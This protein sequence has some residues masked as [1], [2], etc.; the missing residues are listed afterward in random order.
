MGVEAVS[1]L[2]S[3]A[4]IAGGSKG[5][6]QTLFSLLLISAAVLA[7]AFIYNMTCTVTFHTTE[8]H[9]IQIRLS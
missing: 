7:S 4:G 6:T 9:P 5:P 3:S 1:L 2:H 8:D